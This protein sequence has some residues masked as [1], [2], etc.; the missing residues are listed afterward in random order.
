MGPQS[1]YVIGVDIGGTFTDC[2]VLSP[3]GRATLGKAPSTPPSFEVGF[4]DSVESAAHNLGMELSE[5]LSQARIFHGCTVGTNALV[6]RRGAKVGLVTTAGHSESI[7]MMQGGGR[8]GG[9]PA[10]YIANVAMHSKPSPLVPR[11]LVGEVAERVAFDGNILAPAR[12]DHV[13]SVVESLVSKGADAFAVSLL[14][15]VANDAHEVLVREV[16]REVAPDA[17]VSISSEVIPKIGEY[18]RTVATVVNSLVGPDMVSYLSALEERLRANGYQRTV[19]VMSCWGGLIDV[20]E[21]RRLPFLTIGSGPTGGVIGAQLLAKDPGNAHSGA[22]VITADM[23]GTTFDV[24]T[25]IDGATASR[26]STKIDQFEYFVSTIDVR[27]IGAGGGSLIRY[28]GAMRTLRVGPESAGSSPGPVAFRRGGTQATVTDADLVLGYLDPSSVLGGSIQLDLDG[29]TRALASVGRD[30]GL[31]AEETAAA[32]VRIVDNQMADAIRLVSVNQG[33]DPRDFVIYAYGGNGPVHATALAPELGIRTVVVPLGD[34]ASGWSSF[35][36]ASAEAQVLESF[37]VPRTAP[38][39]PDELNAVWET[40]EATALGRIEAIGVHGE[41]RVERLAEMKY[42]SQ[43]SE[44]RIASPQD[45][46]TRETAGELC[47]AFD[48]EYARVYG[49]DTGYALAGYRL[50]AQLVRASGELSE[51]QLAA[52]ESTADAPQLKAERGVIW[53]ERG[54]E[55][56]TTPVYDGTKFRSGMRFEGP[57]IAEF[58]D[59]TVVVRPGQ[60]A[61]VDSL[62]S[63]VV[64]TGIVKEQA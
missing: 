26:T 35:G 47:E 64:D 4:L 9:M 33:L 44:L 36:V 28:D 63:I 32:A 11:E 1:P 60:T 48:R 34:L 24:A 59:T 49:K 61:S 6:E 7:F 16:I 10:E 20:S 15:S 58:P 3:D 55:R 8:L 2:V 62:G 57:A 29:A 13:R 54:L 42:A 17:F 19:A 25:V 39:D 14:W 40:L 38:F 5:L 46:Y 56:I 53:Y 27:S 18:E 22:S 45:R 12:R 50:T 41:V 51:F 43:V 23:G 52:R 37:A 31:T 30:L 21:A